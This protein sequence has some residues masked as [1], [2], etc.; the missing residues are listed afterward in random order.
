MLGVWDTVEFEY[1]GQSKGNPFIDYN[2]YGEFTVGGETKTVSGFYDGEGIYRVR[3][4]PLEE[5]DYTYKIYLQMNTTFA[6]IKRLRIGR[7]MPEL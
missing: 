3:F 4:M 7:I 6:K 1:N 5:G 2:I